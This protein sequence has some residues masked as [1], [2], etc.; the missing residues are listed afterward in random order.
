MIRAVVDTN[1][2]FEGLTRLGPAAEVI[3]SWVERQFHPCVSTALA[4]EYQDVLSRKLGAE[5]SE[6]A[7]MALQAL[8][9]RCEYVPIFYTY[10]PTSSD[11]GDDLVVDCVLNGRAVL[12]TR[13]IKHFSGPSLQLGFKVFQPNEFMLFLAEETRQ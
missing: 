1:V 3:D 9:I 10:R 7:L 6:S 13:N 12:V 8:L 4:L 2:L 11:P 5:R